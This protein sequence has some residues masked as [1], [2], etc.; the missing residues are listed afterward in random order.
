MLGVVDGELKRI[1]NGNNGIPNHADIN[2]AITTMV[3]NN[4]QY[5]K[6]NMLAILS[7]IVDFSELTSGVYC[8]NVSDNSLRPRAMPFHA[9]PSWRNEEISQFELWKT[10]VEKDVKEFWRPNIKFV[11]TKKLK[12]LSVTETTNGK[13]GIAPYIL[14]SIYIESEKRIFLAI[15]RSNN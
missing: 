10:I 2:L 5:E 14:R 12:E 11:D 15:S 4:D 7:G 8:G 6:T 9:I 3:P 1:E 13:D